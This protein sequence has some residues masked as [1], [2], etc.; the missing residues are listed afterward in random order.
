MPDELYVESELKLGVGMV[1]TLEVGMPEG[2]ASGLKFESS[3]AEAVSVTEDGTL[4]AKAEGEAIITVTAKNS[5]V[6]AECAVKVY[7]APEEI[8]PLETEIEL[9]V[10][11]RRLIECGFK[12]ENAFG[13][14]KL[15]PENES[16]VKTE[17]DNALV[18]A[19][20]GSTEVT[21]TAYNGVEAVLNVEVLKAPT[22]VQI[23][24]KL[25]NLKSGESYQ[26][27]YTLVGDGFTKVSYESLDPNIATVDPETG[28]VQAVSTG[29]VF[30]VA[31]TLNG[32]HTSCVVNVDIEKTAQETVDGDFEITFMDIGRNDGILISCGG[33]Y[34]FIDSGMYSYGKRAVE[35]LQSRGITK[36]KYYIGTH[37]HKDHVAGAAAIVAALDVESIIVNRDYAYNCMIGFAETQEEKNI[38]QN[39]PY[40]VLSRGEQIYLG[41]AKITCLGPV[42]I[43][44]YSYRNI[45]ENRNSLVMRVTYGDHSVLLTGDAT[46]T[47]LKEIEEADPG[48]LRAD[49]HKSPH[50]N[51]NL[52]ATLL[53]YI[54]AKLTIIST[55]K[56]A[57]PS[58]SYLN[59]LKQHGSAVAVTSPTYNSHITVTSDG[60]NF[61]TT[62]TK[63]E[64]ITP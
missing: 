24:K 18:G 61:H 17:K 56:D 39:T 2:T 21:I 1:E 10:G 55:S 4:E 28:V 49:I 62:V 58:G 32:L 33:E 54:Q 38:L 50:H 46:K 25:L 59:L 37:A 31:R 8:Y 9:M 3:N 40:M 41:G 44:G 20:A 23:D 15:K 29:T 5:G 34:A 63:G 51:A 30:I 16:I 26:L 11:E 36:L 45:E 52:N 48:C 57:R 27:A 6:T 42:A 12:P 47:E 22:A 13:A 53:N 60:T 7:P 43:H 35:Y 64:V 14:F 19:R